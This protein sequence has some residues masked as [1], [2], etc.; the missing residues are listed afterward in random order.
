M[1]PVYFGR[2]QTRLFVLATVGALWT[3]IIAPQLP[4]PGSTGAKYRTA[5]IVLAV[6]FVAGTVW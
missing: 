5:F 3:L 1:T 4:G 6:V 2:V